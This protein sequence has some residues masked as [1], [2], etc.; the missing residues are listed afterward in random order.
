MLCKR[1]LI[2]GKVQG[3]SFRAHTQR[4]AQQW[5]LKGWVKNL[6]DGRVEVLAWGTEKQLDQLAQWLWQGVPLAKVAGVI[7]EVV[8][9]PEPCSDFTI[10]R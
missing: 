3:V 7:C 4:Q 8:D 5:N 2:S 1:Y 6:P 10:H 9:E